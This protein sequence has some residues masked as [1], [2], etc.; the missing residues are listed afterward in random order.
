MAKGEAGCLQAPPSLL[1]STRIRPMKNRINIHLQNTAV[2]CTHCKHEVP[3]LEGVSG[4]FKGRDDLKLADLKQVAQEK[5][6]HPILLLCMNCGTIME[7]KDGQVLQAT[8]EMARRM[9]DH[10]PDGFQ[11]LAQMQLMIHAL[12]HLR[13]CPTNHLPRN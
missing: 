9:R 5:P 8:P 1:V 7:Y 4:P 3:N 12:W 6:E 2:V 11:A 10:D 13:G